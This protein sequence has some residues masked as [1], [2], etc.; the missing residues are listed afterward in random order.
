MSVALPSWFMTGWRSDRRDLAGLSVPLVGAVEESDDPWEPY[1]L[2][3]AA[4]AVVAPVAEYLKDLQAIGRPAGTQRSYALALLRWFRFVWALEV[5][6]D[7][8]T[9]VEARDFCR[10]LQTADKPVRE[11][12]RHAGSGGER[13]AAARAH[14]AASVNPVTGKSSPDRQYAARTRAHSE[15]VLRSFYA[16]HLEAASGPMVNPFPLVRDRRGERAHAHRSPMAPVEFERSGLYRPKIAVRVPRRIPDDRFDEL[17]AR[18]PS[19]RD[20]ALVAFWVSTGARAAELLGARGCDAEPGRQLIT[21]VRK[22]SRAVQSLPASPDAFVW[23][24]L[25]QAQLEWAVAAGPDDPLWWTLRRP[26]RPL[27]YP[28]A[29]RM[30][31]RVNAMIG[32]NWSLHDLR[33]TAAYRMAPD[34]GMPLTDVQWVLGHAQLTTTQL[35]L[36]PVPEDVIASVLAHHRRSAEHAAA[37][38]PG[39]APGYRPETMDVLF[40]RGRS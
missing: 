31:Q 4:G 20:R 21:V 16:F 32:A 22:G 9:R 17:F 29:Y 26:W 14:P 5:P 23:L 39:P 8:A 2:L 1:R 27:S 6:W 25:Y 37:P 7:Q 3:D 40:G 18:L 10:W 15:T 36:L 35:Y 33:H 24:R 38:D 28:A 13:S 30:F 12:W 11:H 19:H 34:P